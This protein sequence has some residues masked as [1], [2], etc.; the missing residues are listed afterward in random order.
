MITY[1]KIHGFKSF[2]HFEMEFT[3]LTVIAGINASGKS[4]LFDAL[5]LLSRLASTEL[6]TAF[7]E[8]RGNP[9]ELFTMYGDE[10]ASEMHFVVEMLVNKSVSDNWGGEAELKYTRLR[11]ELKIKK[12]KNQFGVDDLVVDYEELRTIKHLD[13][14]WIKKL[15]GRK[16]VE[17]WRPKVKTGRRGTPYIYTEMVNGVPRIIVPQDG[18]PGGNKKAFPA[19]YA[20]QT[21]LSNINSVDFPH[22]FAAK[23]EMQSWNFLQLDPRDLREPTRQEPGMQDTISPGGKNL[24]AAL[25]RI[26]REDPYLLVEISRKLNSFLPNFVEV[27]V[28][29]DQANQ[30]YLI[31]LKSEDGK[32]FSSRVLSEGTLRLLA[33]CVLEKDEKHS[34]LLCFEEPENGIHPSRIRDMAHL[35]R[36]LSADFTDPSSPL[37]QIVVNTHS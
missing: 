6:R 17:D 12:I 32:W 15:I 19:A 1:I 23:R 22:V 3:P 7:N 26:K 29:D 8:Q 13:D 31:R 27:D 11:Y 36:D 24:A 2:H 14:R 34:G 30:Q 28:V 25:F 10:Y 18:T 21:V 16:N 37:R 35:L 20:R 5:K 33:L 9:A 4:N